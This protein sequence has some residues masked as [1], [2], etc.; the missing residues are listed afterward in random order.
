[1]VPLRRQSNDSFATHSPYNNSPS[2]DVTVPIAPLG[3]LSVTA[4]GESVRSALS[5]RD[6]RT[7]AG[8]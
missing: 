1:M 5:S 3:C 6:I 2:L 4:T 8:R 7:I